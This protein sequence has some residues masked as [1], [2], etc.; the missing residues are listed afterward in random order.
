MGIKQNPMGIYE[1]AMPDAY[2][3]DAKLRVAKAA[4]FDYLEISIDESDARL[5]RLD[6]GEEEF[7]TLNAL[8][9]K[10]DL[11]IVSM[12]L[13]GH[14]RFP[15]GSHDEAARKKARIM[16][17]KALNMAEKL[18]IRNIQLAGYDVY[19]EKSD[20]LTIK[21]FREG[22]TS[23][24]RMAEA[25]NIMLSIEIMDTELIGTITRGLSFIEPVRSP[26]LKLY[27]DL[28]NLSRWSDDPSQEL[29]I[30]K[31]SMVAIHLKDTRPDTFKRVPFGEGTVNFP[32]L[33]K[34]L[35]T[36]EYN[37]PFVIEMWA[38]NDEEETEEACVK[39]LKDAR[40]WLEER[41]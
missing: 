22:L 17:E 28:G 37:G 34:T 7:D 40:S 24:A 12:C 3:W 27:P 36:L 35:N 41:M 5:S 26:Y 15:F 8:M 29:F 33:F 13:S 21:R 31:E 10:H 14:R 39:R 1:K 18:H 23:A 32:T 6:W 16:M 11:P 4:G 9:K 25:K 38:D 19:Y 2:D 30:G 20:E